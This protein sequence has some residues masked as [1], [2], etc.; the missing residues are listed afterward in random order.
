MNFK[1]LALSAMVMFS[2]TALAQTAP[3]TGVYVGAT[4]GTTM[5]TNS[6][7][8][9][10]AV[11]G[12]RFNRILGA[13]VTYDQEWRSRQNGGLLMLNGVA[14]LPVHN[15]I[16]PYVLAGVGLGF[17]H[18]N[19]NRA[20]RNGTPMYNVGGGVRYALTSNFDLD[21]RYRYIASIS[22]GNAQQNAS[23]LTFGVNYR[24]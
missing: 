16:R 22:T 20:D 19:Q 11:I 23:M 5:Q 9:T 15:R 13:E 1:V 8:T 2:G 6:D 24:F 21:A 3:S 7:L 14:E 12:Y 4:V 17:D 10:G 18:Y